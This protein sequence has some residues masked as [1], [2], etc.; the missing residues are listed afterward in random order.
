MNVAPN[1]GRRGRARTFRP[2]PCGHGFTLVELLVVIAIIAILVGLLL[3]AVQSARESSRRTVCGNNLK[4]IGLAVQSHIQ[5]FG[6]F[7]NGGLPFTRPRTMIDGSPATF[8]NQ[9]WA[10]G[11]QILPFVE[12]TTLWSDSD[13]TR[14]A[15]TPIPLYFCPTRRPPTSLK[16][17]YGA[18]MNTSR[19]QTDYA[20]NAGTSNR[21]TD[22]G[23]MYG[24]GIDGAICKLGVATRVPAHIT[25]GLS[26]TILV[27]EKRMNVA[28]CM[29][30]QQADDNDGY[31]GGFQDDV[32]RWGAA[33]TPDGDLV[34]T[35][36]FSGP[37]YQWR[38]PPSLFPNIWQFGSS[39]ALGAT[40]VACDGAVRFLSFNVDPQTFSRLCAIKDGQPVSFAGK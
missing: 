15:S 22:G 17:G 11:Y 16:A 32:V 1:R 3:P 5:S 35:F 10:W 4:Q 2:G 25:D 40:F 7:P 31:V 13:D 18:S 19:A 14:V 33:G 9:A 23:G 39:H 30:D 6:A 36:D 21:D 12:Q 37:P 24:N 28:Y 27:G 26:S 20:G 34:P 29:T 8:D 38:Q